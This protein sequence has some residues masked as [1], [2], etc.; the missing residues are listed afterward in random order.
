MKRVFS[1]LSGWYRDLSISKKIY[2]PNFLIIILL[3]GVT[4]YMAN[5]VASDMLIQRTSETT[6][7]SMDIIIQSLNGVLNSIEEAGATVSHDETVQAVLSKLQDTD[8]GDNTDHYFLVRSALQKITYLRNVING[9]TLYTSEGVRVGVGSVSDDSFSTSPLLPR[10]MVDLITLNSGRNIWLDLGK[11]GYSGMNKGIVGLTMLRSIVREESGEILG[12]LQMSVSDSIFSSLYSHLDY[13]RTGRFMVVDNSGSLIYPEMRFRGPFAD[14]LNDSY[15]SWIGE[16]YQQGRIQR[17]DEGDLLVLSR[18][19]DRLNWTIIGIVP[20]TEL[21][22]FGL[23]FTRLVYIIGALGVGLELAFAFLIARG[24][25]KPIVSLSDSMSDAASGDLSIRL[26]E[27]RRDEIGELTGAFNHMLRRMSDLMDRVYIH[28]QRERELELMALQSQINPHF[29]YN[30]LESISSLTQLGRNDDAYN[31]AKSVSLFYRGV[32]SNG[33]P[34][35]SIREEVQTIRHYLIIQKTRYQEKLNFEVDVDNEILDQRIVK[36]SLQPLVE[37]SIYHGLKASRRV[38]F[39]S[40][41]GIREKE[42]VRLRV[43]D[44]GAGIKADRIREV[45]SQREREGLGGF[46]LSSVDQRL[47]QRFGNDFGLSIESSFGE[48][49]RVTITVPFE[50]RDLQEDPA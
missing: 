10:E 17:T 25:S 5:K 35:I 30:T 32:L 16:G 12:I 48:W 3:I 21:L 2:L 26:E 8:P 43:E 34:V 4:V 27:D 11:H 1:G 9:L 46:G 36:L 44:N 33:R 18:R 41:T 49:T 47:K 29:L 39:I 15:L 31:L 14:L 37:N 6:K 40:V 23:R 19:I 38:G 22:A 45:L 42:C 13:G 28:H 50:S 20:L 7:Q 24:I